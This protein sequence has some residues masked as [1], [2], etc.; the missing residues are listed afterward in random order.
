MIRIFEEVGSNSEDE[1]KED[2][3]SPNQLAKIES[4]E[5]KLIEQRKA[6]N[7]WDVPMTPNPEL[8]MHQSE[9]DS[10]VF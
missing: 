1:M 4:I 3:F 9:P 2:V 7:R 10:P 8:P 5:N 6:L